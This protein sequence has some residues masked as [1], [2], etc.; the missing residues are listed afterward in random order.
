M[1]T[2]PTTKEIAMNTS[3]SSS[4]RL[5]RGATRQ[6][7]RKIRFFTHL[8]VYLVVNTGLITLNLLQT[9]KPFWAAAPLL[10]WGI[11]LLFHGLKVFMRLPPTWKQRLIEQ[12]L[13]NYRQ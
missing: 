5:L 1:Q 12:E 6:V 2:P 11:G 8:G 4:S 9:H 10:G 3:A 13:R 7:E